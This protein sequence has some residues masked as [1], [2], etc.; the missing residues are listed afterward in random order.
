MTRCAPEAIGIV[1]IEVYVPRSCVS[2]TALEKADGVPTGK[3]TI[4][5]GQES[6]AFIRDNEDVASMCLTGT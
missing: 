5:L 3:Y 2:Q 6:M 4:G 1:A